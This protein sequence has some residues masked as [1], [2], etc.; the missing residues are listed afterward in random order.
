MRVATLFF[1]LLVSSIV[2]AQETAHDSGTEEQ[3]PRAPVRKRPVLPEDEQDQYEEAPARRKSAPPTLDRETEAAAELLKLSPEKRL[4][5]R[6][7]DKRVEEGKKFRLAGILTAVSGAALLAMGTAIIIAAPGQYSQ[8][9][10]YY[11]AGSSLVALG[12][13]GIGV[14]IPLWVVGSVRAGKYEARKERLLFGA[15]PSRE[16]FAMQLAIQ[17]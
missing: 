13:G 5:L 8:S 15:A 16:G 17:F 4:Q 12:A 11:A 1:A 6:Y 9:Y 7:F 10:Q 2:S 3:R 14:G